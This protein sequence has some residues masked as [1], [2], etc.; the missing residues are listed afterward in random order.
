M[1]DADD[2]GSGEGVS[3]PSGSKQVVS[4]TLRIVA[5]LRGEAEA[6]ALQAAAVADAEA[7]GEAPPAATPFVPDRIPHLRYTFNEQNITSEPATEWALAGAAD[8]DEDGAGGGAGDADTPPCA[9]VYEK[10]FTGVSVDRA[11]LEQLHGR[12]QLTLF[13]ADAPGN[14]EGEPRKYAAHAMLDMSPLLDNDTAVSAEFA[15]LDGDNDGTEGHVALP[16]PPEGFDYFKVTVSVDKPLLTPQ[17]VK[18]L[19]PLAVTIK[20]AVDLPGV[21]MADGDPSLQ[22]YVTPTPYHL[23]RKHCEPV[24]ACFKFFDGQAIP[25]VVRTPGVPY[26]SRAVW[27]VKTVFLAG[28]MAPDQIRELIVQAPLC[29]EVHDRDVPLTEAQVQERRARWEG[30]VAGTYVDPEEEAARLE[31]LAIAAEEEA[32]R[33]AEEAANPLAGTTEHRRSSQLSSAAG[34]GGAGANTVGVG[35]LSLVYGM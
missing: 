34:E 3:A 14:G 5:A 35:C 31:A 7:A 27:N 15:P 17:L 24:F 9:R 19:N 13:I 10:A 20:Q 26:G 28:I 30:I 2:A 6:K 8:G 4:F 29:I 32:A 21:H 33:A 11:W 1:A 23:M 22:R 25:R 12:S 18:E 16:S